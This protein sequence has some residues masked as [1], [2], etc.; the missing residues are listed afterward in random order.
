MEIT[1][2]PKGILQ[3]DD[4]RI[5]FRNFSGAPSKYNR[6]GDRNFAV[7]IPN[8]TLKKV[9][10]LGYPEGISDEERGEISGMSEKEL[11]ERGYA[12]TVADELV[13]RGWN[14]TIKPPREEGEEPLCILKVKVKFN[15]HG[16]AIYLRTNGVTNQL[17]EESVGMLDNI[18]I[19]SV[20]M[21][22]RPYHWEVKGETGVSAYLQS[23]CVTQRIDRFAERFANE[24][25][26]EPQSETDPY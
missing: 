12:R 26:Q 1:F 17:D 15:D 5:I 23:M 18:D 4:A 20:D 6:E 19:L 2:A 3:I 16:P 8:D 24:T 13:A 21:D 14:I 25:V 9:I 11:L 7:V 22:I 10:F